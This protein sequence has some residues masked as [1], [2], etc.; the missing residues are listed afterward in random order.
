[1]ISPDKQNNDQKMSDCLFFTRSLFVL[2]MALKLFI[3]LEWP[4][5]II[6]HVSHSHLSMSS[7]IKYDC[8]FLFFVN[9]DWDIFPQKNARGLKDWD[10]YCNR[11]L[12]L[13]VFDI[14]ITMDIS[15]IYNSKDKVSECII[16]LEFS[17]LKVSSS[18]VWTLPWKE[19]AKANQKFK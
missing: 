4:L 17:S 5:N 3:H 8:F 1:M 12:N 16:S 10:Y 19:M 18:H 2:L 7:Q 9:C 6:N 13:E 14:T 11:F 15:L